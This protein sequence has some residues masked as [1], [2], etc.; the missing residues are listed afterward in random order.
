LT[1]FE[2]RVLSMIFGP[3]REEDESWIKLH[4]EL[5]SPYTSPNIVR[6]IKS[7]RMR[8]AGHVAR[9]REVRGV[10]GVL[11]GRPEEK[12][13]LG[14]PRRRWEDNIKI[15]FGETDRWDEL[16]SAGSR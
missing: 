3:K 11:V 12:R 8:W 13:P 2:K 15:D 6:V 10:Y 4:N 5:H 14:R 16:G 9:V 1:V 7:R